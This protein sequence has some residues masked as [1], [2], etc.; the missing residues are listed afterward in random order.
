MADPIECLLESYKL[1]IHHYQLML[2]KSAI[3]VEKKPLVADR[4]IRQ[5]S[6]TLIAGF[7]IKPTRLKFKG[8][9]PGTMTTA[10]DC[11]RLCHRQ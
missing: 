7:F 3:F 9:Q 4:I 5:L 2:V 1:A 10:G 11:L 6:K 8:I